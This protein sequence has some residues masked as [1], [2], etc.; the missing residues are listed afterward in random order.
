LGGLAISTNSIGTDFSKFNPSSATS[1]YS[2][3]YADKKNTLPAVGGIPSI[4]NPGIR[5]PVQ[6]SLSN[7]TPGPKVQDKTKNGMFTDTN[8]LTAGISR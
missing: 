5:T 6:F 3:T 2:S 7:A 4:A 1:S 8:I